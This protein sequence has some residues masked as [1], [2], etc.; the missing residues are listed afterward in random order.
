VAEH[1]NALGV[2]VPA[3]FTDRP[4]RHAARLAAAHLGFGA[5]PPLEEVLP[6]RHPLYR[7]GPR[8]LRSPRSP[9]PLQGQRVPRQPRP[10]ERGD[11]RHRAAK[12]CH[13]RPASPRRALR[14][15]GAG[16]ALAGWCAMF[17]LAAGPGDLH[18]I[19]DFVTALMLQAKEP[20]LSR[21]GRS[22]ARHTPAPQVSPG[23]RRETPPRR[24]LKPETYCNSFLRL[25]SRYSA[26]TEPSGE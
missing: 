24:K 19:F 20:S 1:L 6:H 16:A 12:P 7:G 2:H 22:H 21:R 13:R 9:R 17:N 10:H 14:G 5:T 4:E 15:R 26:V 11:A 18:D 8:R 25:S 3:Q 23:P